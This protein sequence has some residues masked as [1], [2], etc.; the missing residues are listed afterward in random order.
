VLSSG[1]IG[2]LRGGFPYNFDDSGE[3]VPANDIQLTR[4]LVLAGVFQ[5]IDY[6]R[7]PN[8]L[9]KRGL[10]ALDADLQRFVV[11][12]WLQHQPRSRSTVPGNVLSNFEHADWIKANSP[13]IQ[14]TLSFTLESDKEPKLS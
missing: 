11:H 1:K 2:I 5:A 6:F 3:S 8:V 9:G 14:E 13:G 7:N 12:E 10:Y 4:A